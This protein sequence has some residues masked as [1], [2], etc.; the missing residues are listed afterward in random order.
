MESVRQFYF[1]YSSGYVTDLAD[2]L[3]TASQA[4]YPVDILFE[5]GDIVYLSANGQ[6]DS[7]GEDFEISPGVVIP[8]GSY[9]WPY[10]RAGLDSSSKRPAEL[11]LDYSYGGFYDGQKSSVTTAVDWKPIKNLIF[12]L[13]YSLNQIR[14]PAG[15]FDTRLGYARAQVSFSPDLTWYNLLQ[16]DS[17]SDTVGY[18]TRLVWE[19]RPGMKLYLVLSQNIDRDNSNLTLLSSDLTLKVGITLRF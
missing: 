7:P 8:A 1:I 2:N 19:F 9:W 6:L 5:S 12:R 17:V 10:F 18:N 16:Y 3:E 11:E 14:L 13:G 4:L 15:D